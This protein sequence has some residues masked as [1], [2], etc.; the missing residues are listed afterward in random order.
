MFVRNALMWGA[1]GTVLGLVAAAALSQLM[2]ALLFGIKPTD[3]LTYIAV[4][5]TLLAATAVASYLPARRITRVNPVQ[6]LRAE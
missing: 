2:S 4:A 6:A 5:I 1:I 3:P